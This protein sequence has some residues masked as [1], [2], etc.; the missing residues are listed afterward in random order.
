MP[1][2]DPVRF[3]VLIRQGARAPYRA[4]RDFLTLWCAEAVS[5]S[6]A[7]PCDAIESIGPLA[8][9]IVVPTVRRVDPKALILIGA[10][11]F[12]ACVMAWSLGIF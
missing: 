9:L 10:L 7:Y 4:C 2:G 11:V 3:P 8:D 1:V 5:R 12:I 6:P